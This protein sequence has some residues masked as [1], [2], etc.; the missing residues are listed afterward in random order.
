MD[1]FWNRIIEQFREKRSKQF[2][3]LATFLLK[4]H[5]TA[6]RLTLL[7][8][9]FGVCSIYFLFNNYL[10]FFVFGLLHLITDGLDGVV[11]RV[12]GFSSYGKY[13][14]FLSDRTIAILCLIKL[15]IYLQDY[16]VFIALALNLLTHSISILSKFKYQ[17]LYSRTFMLVIL[18]LNLPAVLFITKLNL[19]VIA[20]LTAG[21]ISLYS[22]VLQF[23]FWLE[24]R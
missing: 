7:S 9:L 2:A 14:D 12:Q 21:V 16:Y 1:I 22:L 5:L 20:Y 24:K 19:P 11:A 8:L 18:F 17:S 3:P 4:I 6:N 13:L 23:K 10:L 15:G